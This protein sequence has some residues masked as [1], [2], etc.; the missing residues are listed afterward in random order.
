[1]GV[2][3]IEAARRACSALVERAGRSGDHEVL[4]KTRS[5]IGEVRNASAP[6]AYAVTIGQAGQTTGTAESNQGTPNQVTTP[7]ATTGSAIA[8]DELVTHA[9]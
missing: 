1:M 3:N 7:S 8:T 9:D 6:T 2:A 4:T 5:S